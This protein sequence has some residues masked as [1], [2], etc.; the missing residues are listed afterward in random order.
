MFGKL[1]TL[2]LLTECQIS[3]GGPLT[4]CNAPE[5][6]RGDSVAAISAGQTVFAL[7]VFQNLMDPVFLFFF[8]F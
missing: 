5:N 6:E 8:F 1:D 7:V 2:D 3:G 4:S